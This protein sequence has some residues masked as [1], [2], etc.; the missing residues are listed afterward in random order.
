MEPAR[1]VEVNDG[2]TTVE[3]YEYDEREKRDKREKREKNGREKNGE[4]NGTGP[5][6]AT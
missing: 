2:E 5:I 3:G 4:K 6:L 1:L